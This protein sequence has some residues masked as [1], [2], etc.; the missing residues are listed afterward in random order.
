MSS[1]V[2][3]VIEQSQAQAS[4]RRKRAA[5]TYRIVLLRN[6]APQAGD[7]EALIEAAAV[8]GRGVDAL[9]EDLQLVARIAECEPLA[10]KVGS[11]Q[12][13]LV[14]KHRAWSEGMVWAEQARKESEEK[15]VTKVMA[16]HAARGKADALFQTAN[17]AARNLKGLREEWDALTQGIALED[18][19]A[20]RRAEHRRT[21]PPSVH[22]PRSVQ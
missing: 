13:D 22:G 18:L 21:A 12:A 19:R 8:L 14:E 9:P 20:A 6:H 2:Q 16:L 4:E 11:L 1:L 15:I 5:E 17:D 3:T 10:E 7:A